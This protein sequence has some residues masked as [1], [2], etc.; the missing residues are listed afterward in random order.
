MII[1]TPNTVIR[2]AEIN[3]NFSELTDTFAGMNTLYKRINNGGAP[4]ARST[5]TSATPVDIP[6]SSFT[7]TP[8]IDCTAYLFLAILTTNTLGLTR[9]AINV[10][11]ADSPHSTY[12]ATTTWQT[13]VLDYSIDMTANTLYTIKA[14][15][16][17][18][19]GGTATVT[20]ASD[21]AQYPG[22]IRGFTIPR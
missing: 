5:T 12:I 13:A 10:N 18:F 3:S 2:S 6:G 8:T 21:D 17:Q 19:S 11:G 20:N 16:T 1:F 15:W 9:H 4:G 7:Y 14:R 22:H